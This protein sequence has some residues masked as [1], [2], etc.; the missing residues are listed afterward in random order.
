[1]QKKFNI[2]GTCLPHLHYMM[3]NRAKLAEVMKMIEAGEY[4]T[5][6]RPRQYGK[7]TTL[8]EMR[9]LLEADPDY[10]PI[11]LDL[12]GVDE[13][14][15]ASDG[16]FATMFIRQMANTLEFKEPALHA[17]LEKQKSEVSD[18]DSLSRVITRLAHQ[19]EQK[20]VLL[21]DE[22]DASSNFEPFLRFLGMLRN[23]YLDR[24]SP[25][26]RTF[27]SVILAGVHDIKSLKLKLRGD[28]VAQY[29]SPWNI[30]ADFEVEMSFRPH[31]I[32]PMLV[33]YSQA[34]GIEIDVD[35]FAEKLYYYTSGY[36]FLVSKLC[37]TIAEKLVPQKTEPRWTPEDLEEAVQ[38][39]LKE[40]NTLFKSLIKNL[41]NNADLYDFTY[42]IIVEGETIPFNPD[43]RIISLGRLYG[44]FRENGQVKVH[45]RIYEQRIYNYMIANTLREHLSRR[46]SYM[47]FSYEKPDGSLDLEKAL[48]RF[49]Q[50]LREQYSKKDQAFLERQW[51]LIFL[52]FLNPIINGRGHM[53]KEVQIS[54]ERRLDVVATYLQHKYIIELKRWYGPTYHQKGLDQLAD[55]L[56]RQEVDEGYLLIFEAEKEKT[57]R[58]EWIEHR[59]KRV[60]A[61]WV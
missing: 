5:I 50:F 45:N 22:V 10:L 41:E 30:A 43:D 29:N 55:Y 33:D 52:A 58:Q 13:K 4:F 54:E 53:F 34:E 61:V 32:A 2:T 49:Q 8:F 59:G 3:D 7:T 17:F 14:W 16:A 6:N 47:G 39:L 20:I 46:Q 25:E 19:V 51:R 37:K 40:N 21:I 60:F 56:D 1:M 23:K 42:Q 36:P 26:N 57:H 24:M 11:R 12:Q 31:E 15:H 18:M 28:Q 48:L 44:I 35:W 27:H 38:L 9:A